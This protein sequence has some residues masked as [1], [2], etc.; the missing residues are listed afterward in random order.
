MKRP[1]AVKEL[2]EELKRLPGIGQKTAERLSFYLM[3]GDKERV[4]KLAR[5]MLNIKDK[6]I[7]C[8]NCHGITEVDPCGICSDQR[9]DHHQICVVEDP[10]D[11]LALERTHCYLG[12]YHVLHGVISPLNGIGPDQL[13]LKELFRRLSSGQVKEL[14]IAT[15]P[16]LE[17][18]ATA[19][20]ISRQLT[21]SGQNITGLKLTHLARGLPVGGSLEY[22]DELT[23][24]R[25]FQGRQQV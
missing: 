13:K 12:L 23:L 17:G 10:L 3:R 25:A 19:M 11:I 21:P 22:S 4:E 24:S 1:A 5:A 8:S 2:I 7:L 15:N 9:R 14:I 6:V 16:T 18:E 20:Y